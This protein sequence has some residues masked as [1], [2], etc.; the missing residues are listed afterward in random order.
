M[1]RFRGFF[2]FPTNSGLLMS[3]GFHATWVCL[4]C[5]ACIFRGSMFTRSPASAV[6]LH[7][8]TFSLF[9]Y[10]NPSCG[11]TE[12][13]ALFSTCALHIISSKTRVCV[14]DSVPLSCHLSSYLPRLWH[15]IIYSCCVSFSVS[16]L[17][18][19]PPLM[20]CIYTNV[21]YLKHYVLA[22]FASFFFAYARTPP[23]DMH[24]PRCKPLVRSF[25]C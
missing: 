12:P 11:G 17:P 25:V 13:S 7:S 9:R 1:L 24:L 5:H 8:N 14:F 6:F 22:C 15:V 20:A 21:P 19:H 18:P 23:C 10:I 4:P 2:L 16:S 3:S